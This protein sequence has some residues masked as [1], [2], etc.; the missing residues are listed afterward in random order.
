MDI[1]FEPLAT[2]VQVTI[3]IQ[4]DFITQLQVEWNLLG[5]YCRFIIKLFF[6]ILT[7]AKIIPEDNK[8]TTEEEME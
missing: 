3:V 1:S 8:N 6:S 4:S 5:I 7:S 2:G